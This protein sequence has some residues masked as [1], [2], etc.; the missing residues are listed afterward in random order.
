MLTTIRDSAADGLSPSDYHLSELELVRGR[1]ASAERDADLDLLATDAVI[2]LAYHLRFGKVDFSAIDPNSNFKPDYEAALGS[3]NP[4]GLLAEAL[5]THRVGAVLEAF[6]P[7]HP[8]YS[9]VRSALARY[10]ALEAGGGWPRVADGPSL[11]T[12]DTGS[13]VVALRNRL[14]AEGDLGAATDEAGADT[15]D[16]AVAEGVRRAQARYGLTADGVAGQR[17]LAAL[18]VPVATRVAQL[19]LSLDRGRLIL[20]DL[21][22][23][24][25]LVNVPGFEA[26]Y[27]D[28]AGV[29]LRSNV[30]VGKTY[31]KTPIFRAEM[32]QV[33]FNPTWTIPPGIMRRDVTPALQKDPD[34]LTKKGYTRVG[35]QI[36]Q[37]PG[38]ANALGRVK[39]DMPNPHLVYLHDTPTR[40]LFQEDARAFSSGCVRVERIRELAAL[41]LG[42]ADTWSATAIDAAIETGKTRFV[43]LPAPVPV[44]FLYWTAV[45]VPGEEAVRFYEDVYRRD[46]AVLG[47]LDGPFRIRP[48]DRAAIAALR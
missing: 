11:K 36:V 13:R 37:P 40:G 32:T 29:R 21:P 15:F 10:R 16:Q 12:G 22:Q 46:P 20:H 23:R 47:A 6:R 17:T 45:A 2:R 3:A 1:P 44:L 43:K 39:L 7:S 38:P 42:D 33:V 8:V 9:S 35:S 14:A 5:A 48:T 24:L 28:A 27:V 19:R 25:V 30:I 4:A 26:Y 34:Y 31:A 18:N 41:V